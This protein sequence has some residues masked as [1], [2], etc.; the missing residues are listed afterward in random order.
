MAS[1]VNYIKHLTSV[2][3]LFVADD[4][5]NPTHISLYL[6]LFQYW[7]MNRFD[8]PMSISRGEIMK[9][10]K[11]RSN[12]T[13]LRC[14][15]DLH[16]WNYLVYE[17]SHNPFKGSQVSLYNFC[18]SSA[19]AMIHNRSIFEQASIHNSSKNEQALNPSINS[20]NNKQKKLNLRKGENHFS[21]PS[22]D[23]VLEF[24]SESKLDVSEAEQFFN[25][26]QSNGWLIAGK[27]KMKDWRDSAQSWI[28]RSEKF[29]ANKN[30]E[31]KE[32]EPEHTQDQYNNDKDYSVPL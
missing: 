24:F 18:T 8:N 22:K 17:P 13:Y 19:Q 21:P 28:I 14:I 5:L 16:N 31:Q 29:K 30:S 3:E 6:A 20:I 15:K 32:S 1:S 10:S 2:M 11:V 12:V 7:N 23:E 9:L 4:R 27:S 26:Y 25:H